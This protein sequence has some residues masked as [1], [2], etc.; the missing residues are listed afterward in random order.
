M[1]IIKITILSKNGRGY[2]KKCNLKS[3]I[4]RSKCVSQIYELMRFE[5]QPTCFTK[6]RFFS[7]I[8]GDAILRDFSKMA[9]SRDLGIAWS[10]DWLT[11]LLRA[12]WG[13]RLHFLCNLGHFWTKS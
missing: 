11:H 12:I 7:D 5:L 9:I 1:K 6:T 8:S 10:S 2:I 3:Q 4:A 13:L